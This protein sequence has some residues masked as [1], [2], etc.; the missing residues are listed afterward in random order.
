LL[1]KQG[2]PQSAAV[3]YRTSLSMARTFTSAQKGLDRV[4]ASE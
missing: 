2:D 1:E 3:E 4:A